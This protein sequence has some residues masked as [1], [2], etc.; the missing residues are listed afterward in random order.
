MIRSRSASPHQGSFLPV[1]KRW[2]RGPFAPAWWRGTDEA[3]PS[4]PPPSL[5]A[6]GPLPISDGEESNMRENIHLRPAGE[7]EQ[8]PVRQ[9]LE[10]GFGEPHPPLALQPLVESLP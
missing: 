4:T 6:M 9:E 3:S 10:A 8:G 2:G 1:A 7:V 5:L